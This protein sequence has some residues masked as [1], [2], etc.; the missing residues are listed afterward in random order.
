[1]TKY[2]S[3]TP[4][5]TSPNTTN[6]AIEV[7]SPLLKRYPIFTW[8]H[9]PPWTRGSHTLKA[10]LYVE[11]YRRD[12]R[13]TVAFNGSFDFGRSANNPLDTNW[14]YSNASLG[15]Y[16]TYTEVTNRLFMHEQSTGYEW[17]LQ[18]NW[19][20]KRRLTLDYGMRFYI[21]P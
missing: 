17:D 4:V 18:D 20:L 2:H 10:G 13:T 19:K 7:R 21:I 12:Q 11:R 8:S 9:S 5:T 14:S 1:H 16:N 3:N 15:V 6:L